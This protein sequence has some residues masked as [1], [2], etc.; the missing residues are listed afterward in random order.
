MRKQEIKRVDFEHGT[1]YNGDALRVLEM[2]RAEGVK[3]ELVL[4]DPPYNINKAKWDKIRDYITWS[5]IW[6]NHLQELLKPNGS[7]YFF[8]NDM[9]QIAQLMEWIR[10]HSRFNFNSFI[11]WD[12]ND[13]RA[14]SWKNLQP[15]NP[16]RCWFPTLEYCLFY[17]F[18]DRTGLENVMLDV[19]NFKT[20]RDYS[21][22][23][24]DAIGL[25]LKQI[26]D[27]LGHSKAEHFFRWGS[28]QWGLCTPETYKELEAL[29]LVKPFKR[30]E[31][32][33]LRREYEDLRRE[34]EDL[35]FTFNHLGSCKNIVK[36]NTVNDGS[37]HPTQKPLSLIELIIRRSSKPGDLVL[38]PFGGSGTTA[39]AAINNGRR[40][41]LIEKDPRYFEIICKRIG[42]EGR[43][44]KIQF[45]EAI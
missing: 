25:T 10:Q 35:R 40:F 31:Y 19:N 34:Y 17:T 23:Y 11:V 39:I 12:K 26:N 24:Q 20:L 9:P 36:M 7:F 2:L 32:E 4:T 15:D 16:L 21:K 14:Q 1:V 38:D 6:I 33:D 18:Q 8:H 28:T 3:T 22:Q 45:K 13:F 5:G 41:I 29:P 27:V 42:T 43:Q 44:L 30:R 37:L